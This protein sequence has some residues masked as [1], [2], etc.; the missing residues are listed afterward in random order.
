[1][2][3]VNFI[4]SNSSKE[5]YSIVCQRKDM[6]NK[7]FFIAKLN[8]SRFLKHIRKFLKNF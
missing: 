8:S 6:Q 5:L 2:K 3:D 1:M 7:N 4:F